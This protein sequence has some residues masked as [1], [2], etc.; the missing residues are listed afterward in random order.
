MSIIN[1]NVNQLSWKTLH[2]EDE[3]KLA[4]FS[5]RKRPLLLFVVVV[6]VVVVALPC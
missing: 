6:V 2:D 3:F 1:T 4:N 5:K